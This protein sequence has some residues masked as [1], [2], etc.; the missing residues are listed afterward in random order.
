MNET[1][2]HML[3]DALKGIDDESARHW[4]RAAIRYLAEGS[5]PRHLAASAA[6]LREAARW[7]RAQS[8]RNW[9]QSMAAQLER[10]AWS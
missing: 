10:E 1:L 9:L 8:L 7:T 5:Q 3:Q 6:C 4:I 2:S